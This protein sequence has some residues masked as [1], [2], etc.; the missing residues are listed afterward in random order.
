MRFLEEVPTTAVRVPSFNMAFLPRFD[1]LD[2]EAFRMRQSD[3]RPIRKHFY[4]DMGPSGFDIVTVEAALNRFDT[5]L[6]RMERLLA[7]NGKW[8]VGEDFTIAD[9]VALPLVD[10]MYDLK[11]SG[12]DE[13]YPLVADWYARASTTESFV[14]TFHE[15]ARLSEFLEIVPLN[16]KPALGKNREKTR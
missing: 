8:L 2:D 7:A 9:A 10:R 15:K 12:W 6:A 1:G 14:K 13:A 4:R 16:A 5:S 11:L 3:I